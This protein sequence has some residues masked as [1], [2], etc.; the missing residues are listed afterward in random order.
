[1]RSI[2]N[3]NDFMHDNYNYSIKSGGLQQVPIEIQ[4]AKEISKSAPVKKKPI[5]IFTKIVNIVNLPTSL[6]VYLFEKGIQ[7]FKRHKTPIIKKSVIEE[8]QHKQKKKNVS[9]VV[10]KST[11]MV[12]DVD[13]K[14]NAKCGLL[15]LES[16]TW[17]SLDD[18][19]LRFPINNNLLSS[20][21]NDYIVVKLYDK[22]NNPEFEYLGDSRIDTYPIYA[23]KGSNF[24]SYD[25]LYEEI[26]SI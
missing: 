1:M 9:P 18:T 17:S 12:D 4:K 15:D 10:P 25:L 20:R 22:T 2:R 5:T 14:I 16:K 11:F 3:F 6:I 7:I 26:V 24:L 8:I 21:L 13:K 23:Y 19:N